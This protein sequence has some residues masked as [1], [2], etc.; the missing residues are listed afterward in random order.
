MSKPLQATPNRFVGM[1]SE[2]AFQRAL[3]VYRIAMHFAAQNLGDLDG[4]A[5]R[6][7]KAM[8]WFVGNDDGFA[9]I[10]SV[11]RFISSFHNSALG[12]PKMAREIAGHTTLSA[13]GGIR[14]GV[15]DMTSTEGV[16]AMLLSSAGIHISDDGTYIL[17]NSG[18]ARMCRSA[19]VDGLLEASQRVGTVVS[20]YLDKSMEKTVSASPRRLTN[21][22][23]L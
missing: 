18:E 20:Q 12:L 16:K 10:E 13:E 3:P 23:S 8:D 14:K 15:A 9:Q 4:G 22:P 2:E 6:R 21:T 11:A 17:S 19:S 7:K 1:T 5:S